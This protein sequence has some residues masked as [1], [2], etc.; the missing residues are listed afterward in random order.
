MGNVILFFEGFIRNPV[1]LPIKCR[2]P[3]LYKLLL[4]LLLNLLANFSVELH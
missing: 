3:F 2:K 4:K 1:D